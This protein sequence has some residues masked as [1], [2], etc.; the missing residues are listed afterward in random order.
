HR[1]LYSFPT[2]RASD[3]LLF[4]RAVEHQCGTNAVDAHIEPGRT[5]VAHDF[6]VERLADWT[7][8]ETAPLLWPCQRE[9]ILLGELL[10]ESDA[11]RSEEHTS[12]LQSRENL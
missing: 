7:R 6:V 4:G 3:L 1:V 10:A 11:C 5:V 8:S 9:P 12:E 2:R